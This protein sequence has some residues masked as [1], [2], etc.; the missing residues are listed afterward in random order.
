MP[1]HIKEDLKKLRME[2]LPVRRKLRAVR[3]QIR[4]EV[5]NLGRLLTVINL[6]AGPLFVLVFGAVVFTLRRRQRDA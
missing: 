1:S 5:E 4:E 6:L 2:V 3:R